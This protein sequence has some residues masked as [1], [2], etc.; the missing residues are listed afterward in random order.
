[1][2]VLQTTIVVLIT[3]IALKLCGKLQ[4]AVI[5]SRRRRVDVESSGASG[6][7]AI[8]DHLR[9]NHSTPGLGAKVEDDHESQRQ[10][11]SLKQLYYKLH[12]LED[13]PGILFECREFFESLLSET[14]SAALKDAAHAWAIAEIEVR[15][16][17]ISA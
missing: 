9:T 6:K 10:L 4:C 8:R 13:H 1:M 14:L 16:R 3:F 5:K 12:N 7:H 11:E 2:S 17:R 15:T